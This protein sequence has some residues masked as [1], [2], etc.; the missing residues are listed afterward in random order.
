MSSEAKR[1]LFL[2]GSPKT[3]GQSVSEAL[4]SYLIDKMEAR[5]WSSETIFIRTT[6]QSAKGRTTLLEAVEDTDLII[7]SFPLYVDSLP[8]PVIRAMELISERHSKK[9]TRFAA[10]SNCGF[11][12]AQHNNVALAICQRFAL[13]SGLEWAGG[14]ALGMGGA[15]SGQRLKDRGGMVRNIVKSLDLTVDALVENKPVPDEA[16]RLMAKPLIPKRMYT[17]MG[18]LEWRQ[19]AKRYGVR[20]KLRDRP[21]QR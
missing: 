10:I 1:V 12:E 3:P 20:K 8:A 18:N 16:I 21:Y 13:V 11:P 6:L 14:L 15:V 4:G 9:N 7:L 2:V 17:T 5:G 19:K